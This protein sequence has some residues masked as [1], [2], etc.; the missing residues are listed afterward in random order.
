MFSV[1]SSDRIF[2]RVKEV[3]DRRK[4]VEVVSPVIAAVQGRSSSVPLTRTAIGVD[5]NVFLRIASHASSADLID[6]LNG[7]HTAPV[8]L[9]GQAIQEFWNNQLH[10]VK[11]YADEVDEA[12]TKLDRVL[13]KIDD[14]FN[15]FRANLQ[16]EL[17]EFRSSHGHVYSEATV[18]KTVSF[19]ELIQSRAQVPYVPRQQFWEIAQIRQHTK[20][21]P[22]FMDK[23]FGDFFVWADFLAGVQMAKSGSTDF[24]L[25]V[26]ITNDVKKDWS[27]AGLAHPIL[28]AECQA[29]LGVPFETWNLEQFASRVASDGQ[30][31]APP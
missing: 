23:G 1:A 6:Y 25:A 30:C 11:T 12:L 13:D 3:L 31:Q 5:A 20:T 27:R 26:L 22:G 15:D 9:P 8:V 21:P 14:N 16:R 28:V 4:S 2:A 17:S 19:L 10:A 24:E 7:R 18:R 29:L